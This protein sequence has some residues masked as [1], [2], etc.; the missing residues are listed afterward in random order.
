MLIKEC[1]SFRSD[2]FIRRFSKRAFTVVVVGSSIDSCVVD[3]SENTRRE[4]KKKK[5]EE[6]NAKRDGKK[7]FYLFAVGIGI[8][9]AVCSSSFPLLLGLRVWACHC[10]SIL[11]FDTE[12]PATNPR[13]SVL[14]R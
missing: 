7:S 2:A 10:L 8:G 9:F 14:V 11:V 4:E 6:A 5:K 1:V 12:E 3:G 13:L